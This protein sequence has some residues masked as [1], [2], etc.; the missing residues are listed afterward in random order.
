MGM[1]LLWGI[2]L[3]SSG[4]GEGGAGSLVFAVLAFADRYQPLLAYCGS[5]L[6]PFF[7]GRIQIWRGGGKLATR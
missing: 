7:Q 4:F 6:K 3:F 2:G 1:L 5:E